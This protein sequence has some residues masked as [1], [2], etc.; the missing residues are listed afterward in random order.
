MEIYMV[1]K[2]IVKPALL[3]TGLALGG[4]AQAEAPSAQALAYTCAGCHGTNGASTG[5]ATPSLA[6][7][8]KAYLVEAMQ[9]YRAGE[10]EATIM[11][12]IAKGYSDEEFE[13]MG[14]FFE[15]QK[16]VPV[17]GQH[18]DAALAEKGKKLHNKYCDKCHSE[19]G[20]LA[21]DDAGLLS[22]NTS[23]FLRYSLADFQDGTREVPKKMKKKMKKMLKKDKDAIEKIVNYY[24][25]AK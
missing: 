11:T 2:S 21:E 24:S 25:S 6:G 9:A 7:L 23:Y 16:V 4:L 19:G 1:V 20:T 17:A 18:Y 3:A 5:P 13:R 22:G 8:S 14:E 15:A 12:R 10:R